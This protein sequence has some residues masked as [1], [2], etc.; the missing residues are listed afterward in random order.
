MVGELLLSSGRHGFMDARAI[1]VVNQIKD[2]DNP[3]SLV[4]VETLLGMDAIFHGGE[5]QNFSGSP[6]TL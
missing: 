5:T 3:V 6:L 4:L 1:S 2:G